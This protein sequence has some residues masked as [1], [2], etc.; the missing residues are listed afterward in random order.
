MRLGWV[1]LTTSLL[2]LALVNFG[3]SVAGAEGEVTVS[4]SRPGA[5]HAWR[6]PR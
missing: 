1:L 4:A 5:F 3:A 6:T 2:S